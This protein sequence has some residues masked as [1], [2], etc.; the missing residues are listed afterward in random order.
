M[1]SLVYRC[2]LATTTLDPGESCTF[3]VGW[4]VGNNQSDIFTTT[5]LIFD[6]VTSQ[7]TYVGLT[8]LTTGPIAG[9]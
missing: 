2:A 3:Y 1:R 8:R 4:D 7:P 6:N 9:S 5:L